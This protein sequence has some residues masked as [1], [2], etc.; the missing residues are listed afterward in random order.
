MLRKKK[1]Y[2]RS[3]FSLAEIDLSANA[4]WDSDGITIAGWANGTNGPLP[5]Q[6]SGPV[7]IAISNDNILYVTDA[8]NHRIIVI[9]LDSATPN[10][11][12][13]SGCGASANQFCYP[14]DSFPTNSSLYVTDAGNSRIQ[15]RAL[16]SSNVTSTVSLGSLYAAF[17]LYVDIHQNIYFSEYRNHTVMLFHANLLSTKVV[18]GT[19]VQGSSDDQ[20]NTPYGI[21]VD[22]IGILYVADCWN[23]RIMKWYQGASSG[24]RVAG[25]GTSGSSS[26]QLTTP[27]DIIVD[28]NQHMY[29][30]ESGNARIIRWPPNSTFGVCIA[31]CTGTTGSGSM[32]LSSPHSLAF[33]S[34]GSLYVSDWFGNR[35]QKFSILNYYSN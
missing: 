35:V 2:L 1:S 28:S 22:Q 9:H 13:G 4:T 11:I 17:Y 3:C 34:H 16:N 27:T 29:I 21:F 6:L 14:Y 7:G 8:G 26:T 19:G 32:Q 24:I 25:D 33:D 15:E 30:S 10:Y 12:I 23:H 5:S 18:A 20:F 31:A